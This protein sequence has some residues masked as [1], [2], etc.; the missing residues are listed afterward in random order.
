MTARIAGVICPGDLQL[1][2]VLPI[3]LIEIRVATV[4]GV[5][6]GCRPVSIGKWSRCGSSGARNS[7]DDQYSVARCFSPLWT[8]RHNRG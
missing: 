3:Y 4:A 5:S 1:R 6:A 7:D 2:D 8:S